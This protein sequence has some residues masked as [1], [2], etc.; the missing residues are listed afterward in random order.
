MHPSLVIELREN[1]Y[2]QRTRSQIKFVSNFS[3]LTKRE[4]N[5]LMCQ[6]KST[7]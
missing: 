5:I 3:K 4:N 7:N 6:L 2:N 1:Q